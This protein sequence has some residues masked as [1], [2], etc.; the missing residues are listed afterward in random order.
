[1]R[2][3][4]RGCASEIKTDRGGRVCEWDRDKVR[5][6]RQVQMA[7]K[8]KW[9]KKNCRSKFIFCL[10]TVMLA[11]ILSLTL[12]L[13]LCHSDPQRRQKRHFP[14]VFHH[15]IWIL[16]SK[17]DVRRVHMHSV[18]DSI[19]SLS[20]SFRHIQKQGARILNTWISLIQV[21]TY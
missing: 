10:H 6:W 20:L 16:K 1:M 21:S 8:W 12:S 17:G 9:Q 19:K 15:F 13:F 3:R 14:E 18:H 2:E 7:I 5:Y 4:E 11:C